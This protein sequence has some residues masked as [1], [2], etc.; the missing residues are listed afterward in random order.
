MRGGGL[1]QVI[2]GTGRRPFDASN[3]ATTWDRLSPELKSPSQY[4]LPTEVGLIPA[5]LKYSEV[6]NACSVMTLLFVEVASLKAVW[7]DFWLTPDP[8]SARPVFSS[9]RVGA[10]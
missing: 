6:T 3:I 1:S 4:A 8:N 2:V 5:M 10:W 7:S 9:A